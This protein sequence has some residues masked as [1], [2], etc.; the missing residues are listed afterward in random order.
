MPVVRA[1]AAVGDGRDDRRRARARRP[2]RPRRRR[3]R[4]R[5]RPGAAPCAPRRRRA[6]PLSSPA[7]GPRSTPRWASPR[8]W[9]TRGAPPGSPG[10]GPVAAQAFELAQEPPDRRPRHRR[11]PR[12]RHGRHDRRD[13][14]RAGPGRRIAVI[15]GSAASP[16]GAAADVVVSH[17]GD[18]PQLVPHRRLRLAARR[19]ERG[20]G[21]AHGCGAAAPARSRSG[22]D[23]GIDAAWARRRRRAARDRRSGGR[24]PT[25]SHLLVVASGVD[26]V[27][28]RELVLKVE[29]AAW[30][31]S[32]MRDL[33]TFLHGHLPATGAST[34][35][36][37]ILTTGTRLDART[38]RARQALAA[39]AATGIVAG[40]ILGEA[41]AAR[42][43]AAPHAGRPDRRPGRRPSGQRGGV[44]ARRGRTAPARHARGRRGARHQPRPDPPRRPG[45]P[46]RGRAGGRPRGLT[47]PPGVGYASNSTSEAR[48]IISRSRARK[49]WSISRWTPASANWRSRERA[50]SGVP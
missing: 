29:E 11:Q 4:E 41:R 42:I 10:S 16:A 48:S 28:A 7:A 25:R 34:A 49:S 43:P 6:V 22:S 13:G 37:L 39:A 23:A 1:G 46:P 32:A 38:T 2:D 40:A 21:R 14:R 44:A 17:R 3:R 30:V 35:L 27:T 18:G 31:P 36:V 20:R 5:R 47:G 9:A 45:L 24:S 12:G 8:S 19:R 26:R 50:S 33:E 15:T